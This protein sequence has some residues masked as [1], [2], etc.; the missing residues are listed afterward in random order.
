MTVQYITVIYSNHALLL[1]IDQLTRIMGVVGTPNE[2]FMAKIQS[3]EARNY[4]RYLSILVM[5]TGSELS[6]SFFLSLSF[7]SLSLSLSLSLSFDIVN[8]TY[9]LGLFTVI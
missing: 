8:F 5:S 6:L 7:V 3:D 4:I 1:D 2:E 9:Q